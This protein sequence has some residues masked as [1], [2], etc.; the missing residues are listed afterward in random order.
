MAAAQ[1]MKI[2]WGIPQT[3]DEAARNF[4]VNSGIHPTGRVISRMNAENTH[5][6][7]RHAMTCCTSS[8]ITGIIPLKISLILYY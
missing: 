3:K 7:A 8:I 6:Y 4:C 5:I 2:T 1:N